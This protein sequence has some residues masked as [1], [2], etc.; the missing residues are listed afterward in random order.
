[1]YEDATL[2]ESKHDSIMSEWGDLALFSE[3]GFTGNEGTSFSVAVIGDSEFGETP[4]SLSDSSGYFD[5]SDPWQISTTVKLPNNRLVASVSYPPAIT[6]TTTV[7]ISEKS[8]INGGVSMA[9]KHDD[10]WDPAFYGAAE[11]DYDL[12]L[13][14][15][16]FF[17]VGT[18]FDQRPK[19]TQSGT[20]V[21]FGDTKFVPWGE[22]SIGY[23]KYI[24]GAV[25]GSAY[26][27]NGTVQSEFV[28]NG[29]TLGTGVSILTRTYWDRLGNQTTKREKSGPMSTD[30]AYAHTIT[31]RMVGNVKLTYALFN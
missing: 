4:L 31:P 27:V 21:Y 16:G 17:S 19:V 6:A 24:R 3:I 5:L 23:G 14:E 12:K 2:Y 18:G 26:G 20:G 29:L 8:S 28:I 7:P 22:M 30:V 10:D 25:H 15:R 9:L 13:G 1:M 11:I